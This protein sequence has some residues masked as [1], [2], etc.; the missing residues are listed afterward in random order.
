M[1]EGYKDT[2]DG[3]YHRSGDLEINQFLSF[4]NQRLH[5]PSVYYKI[6]VY[7]QGW[8]VAKDF[9]KVFRSL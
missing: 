5:H 4:V 6:G 3:L 1:D 2:H 8:D 7:V 9:I